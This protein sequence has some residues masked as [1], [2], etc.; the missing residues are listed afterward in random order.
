MMPDDEILTG[1]NVGQ[2]LR[3]GDRVHRTA[4]PWTPAIQRLLAHLRSQGLA[5]VPE[6]FGLDEDGREILG[7]VQGDVP[8]Y[9]MPEWVWSDENLTSA[10][11]LLRELHDATV[12]YAD[13]DAHWRQPVHEPVE[14]ICHNDVAPYNMVF[15]DGQLQGLIDF[16]MASPGPRLWDFAYL[17]YRTAPLT[18]PHNIEAGPF[19]TSAQLDRLH[20]LLDAYGMPFPMGDVLRMVQA[21]LHHL[22]AFSDD[23]ADETGRDDLR[24]HA[25]LYR[26]DI[27]YVETLLE[28]LP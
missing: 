15:V 10:G 23:L 27:E 26:S 16:D 2:T 17:A 1:G 7:F 24:D 28:E 14:V 3:R 11:R 18:A 4:G 20:C 5:W 6:P 13:P 8:G 12:G 22:A 9:P 21:R 19:D 25:R